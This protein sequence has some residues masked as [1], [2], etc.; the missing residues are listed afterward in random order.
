MPGVAQYTAWRKIFEYR[1]I[2]TCYNFSYMYL[3]SSFWIW[4]QCTKLSTRELKGNFLKTYFF[5]RTW[6]NAMICYST[7]LTTVIMNMWSTCRV[8]FRE[9][10]QNYFDNCNL[11]HIKESMRLPQILVTFERWVLIWNRSQELMIYW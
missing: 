6:N 2:T 7:F 8:Q 11:F 10:L 1:R 5:Y 4:E 3:C 9:T